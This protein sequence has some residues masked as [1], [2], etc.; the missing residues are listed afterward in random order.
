MFANFSKTCHFNKK[1]LFSSQP[2]KKHY[3][4]F[5]CISFPFF[6]L[7]SFALS[8]IKKTKA[9]NDI[10]FEA[11]FLTPRQPAKNDFRTPTHYLC[12]LDA[13][14]HKIGKTKAIIFLDRFLTTLARFLTQQRPHLG[15]IFDSTAHIY[16]YAVKL[17]TGPRFG[18]L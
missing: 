3:F 17:K 6:H 11:P 14:K 12:F 15:Q 10:F 2:P 5:F 9:K 8:K 13:Q 1:D 16:I 18:V 4:L 7:F